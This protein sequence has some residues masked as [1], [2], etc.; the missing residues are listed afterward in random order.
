MIRYVGIGLAGM[1]TGGAAAN[2][3]MMVVVWCI[4]TSVWLHPDSGDVTSSHEHR[5]MPAHLFAERAQQPEEEGRAAEASGAALQNDNRPD[6]DAAPAA[7]RTRQTQRRTRR[8]TASA[9]APQEAPTASSD[10]GSARGTSTPPLS[11]QD[12]SLAGRIRREVVRDDEGLYHIPRALAEEVSRDRSLV[13]S[14]VRRVTPYESEDGTPLGIQLHGVGG[15]LSRVGVRDE[16]VL[17][18]VNGI[19]LDAPQRGAAAA[20]A[21]RESPSITLVVYRNG[22]QVALRYALE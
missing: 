7:P 4:P 18:S 8:E 6:S 12:R 16:D 11:D 15:L 5:S 14:L 9:P 1:L 3:L 20:R 13:R 10:E 21:L 22:R 2:L 17:L 19:P